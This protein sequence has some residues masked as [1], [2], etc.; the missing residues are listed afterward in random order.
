[1]IPKSSKTKTG[2][3][4]PS[5]FDSV[6]DR[7]LASLLKQGDNK[8]WTYIF[9]AAVKATL[10]EKSVTCN[11][12]QFKAITTDLNIDAYEI[13]SQLYLYMI[14]RRKIDTFR[15]GNM[16]LVNWLR[17]YVKKFILGYTKTKKREIVSDDPLKGVSIGSNGPKDAE[18]VLRLSFA[19]LW[20]QN[21][22]RAYV[23]LLKVHEFSSEEI[24]ERLGLSSSANVDQYHFRAKADLKEIAAEYSGEKR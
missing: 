21:P 19:K 6:S 2:S 10:G 7:E 12:I 18:E 24:R 3:K 15:Y 16:R 17:M 5:E 20:R 22:M 23:Y 1:M 4:Y 11:G 8:A 9:H 13:L 14:G